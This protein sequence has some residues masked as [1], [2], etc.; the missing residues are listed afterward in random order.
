MST[1]LDDQ[2]AAAEA[3]TDALTAP[4]VAQADRRLAVELDPAEMAELAAHLD[5]VP[6]CPHLTQAPIQPALILAG[7]HDAVADCADC[8][9]ARRGRVRQCTG[10]AQE[11]SGPLHQLGHRLG[12]R[13]VVMLLC[14][15]CVAPFVGR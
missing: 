2:R 6:P 10:C 3:E 15:R 11:V 1:A 8:F 4:F 7:P 12:H 14:D 9:T 13:V 5:R